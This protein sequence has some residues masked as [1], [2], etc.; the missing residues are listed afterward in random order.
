M[1]VA[2]PNPP[3]SAERRPCAPNLLGLIALAALA[4]AA[5]S[6]AHGLGEKK[7][8]PPHT[9]VDVEVLWRPADA[10]I[11]DFQLLVDEVAINSPGT[12]PSQMS[13][14]LPIGE[15]RVGVRGSMGGAPLLANQTL[16]VKKDCDNYLLVVIEGAATPPMAV[17]GMEYSCGGRPN[18]L[19]ELA[20]KAPVCPAE[21][22]WLS[23]ARFEPWVDA[24]SLW[25]L[26]VQ[27]LAIAAMQTAVK[28]RDVVLATCLDSKR[29][30]L[31]L[32]TEQTRRA[33]GQV[34]R[35]PD[36]LTRGVES[37]SAS[38]ERA[39][40]LREEIIQCRGESR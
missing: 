30:A 39:A 22:A 27:E 12:L 19:Q 37:V 31:K 14:S 15:R 20:V 32:V 26:D 24:S 11:K 28:E 6:C 1:H 29:S 36:A 8:L 10:K 9:R 13:V 4:F 23:P 16:E 18:A 25:M 21:P 35:N 33:L 7:P 17:V 3:R 5:L 2:P 40:E 34:A 38:C